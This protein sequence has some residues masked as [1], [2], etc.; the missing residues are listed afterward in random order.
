M[1]ITPRE[2]SWGG[3]YLRFGIGLQSDF[4]GDNQFNLLA[5]YRRTW[6]N[7]YGAEWLVE[8]Q[9]GQDTHLSSE[10]YQPLHEP[11]VWF[12][13]V[14]GNIGQI[15]RNVYE[16]DNNIANYLVGN[17]RGGID[18]GAVL[19]T[20]GVVRLGAVW[21]KI[22]AKVDIG[23]PVLP[24]IREV[25]AGP[26]LQLTLDQLDHAFFAQ[27][28]YSLYLS[29]Y[30]ATK[31]FGS[32]I[33]YQRIQGFGNY[34]RSWGAH[35]LNLHVEGGS[36]LGTDMPAYESFLLG[37]PLRLSGFRIGQYAGNEFAFGRLMYYNRVKALPDLLGS[38]VY[39]GAS[40][41]VGRMF[42]RL[43]NL[44][45]PGTLYSGSIFLGADTFA[46]PAYLGVGVGNGGSVSG[47]LLLGAP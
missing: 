41:E 33:D 17:L 2:K 37:G 31:S 43:G 8:G 3:D 10:F 27:D 34:A 25:T 24:S 32:A 47:Y 6:L 1:V 5:Q 38:G 21:T 13:S 30:Q 29:A 4:Q 35:T 12:A 11:G 14:Y 18:L 36:A 19:G 23:D 20:K 40:A 42:S 9:V 28:G 16:G 26:R 22:N 46:G 15:T 44:P 39:L 45:V 7:K